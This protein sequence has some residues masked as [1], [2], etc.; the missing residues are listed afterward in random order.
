MYANGTCP[1]AAD[2]TKLPCPAGYAAILGTSSLCALLEIGLSFMPPNILTMLFPPLVP[3]PTVTLI[4]VS[5]IQSGLS[6][7]AGRSGL[8]SS[9]PTSGPFQLCPSNDSP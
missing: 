7:C 6:E 5:L 3:G 1:K 2:G 4:G 9:R 8:Y